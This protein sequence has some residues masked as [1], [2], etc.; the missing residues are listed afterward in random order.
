[1]AAA[2]RPLNAA[3]D[4]LVIPT[5]LALEAPVGPRTLADRAFI[6]LRDAIISV[7]LEPGQRLRLD[8][9]AQQLG[10]SVM[11]VREALRRLEAAAL[12]EVEPHRGA[13]VA[14]L[15]AVE[16][17]E[18]F[19]L[20]TLI[21]VVAIRRGAAA[22]GDSDTAAAEAALREYAVSLL[23]EDLGTVTDSHVR[24]HLALYQANG[25]PW[26]VRTLMPLWETSSRYWNWVKRTGWEADNLLHQHERLLEL[27]AA[28]DA[29][30]AAAELEQHLLSGRDM[31]MA[32]VAAA[33][34]ASTVAITAG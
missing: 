27:C 18:V 7:R 3:P 17:V 34:P 31:L 2:R 1:M 19:N 20:R 5:R 21:E 6:E 26:L 32:Q 10:M 4:P 15:S 28:G 33:A 25:Q 11:P 13:T 8:D 9:V 16:L 29:D 23:G 24:F 22:F 14:R 30:E 12:I